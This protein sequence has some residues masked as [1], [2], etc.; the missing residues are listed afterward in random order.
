MTQEQLGKAKSIQAEI[1]GQKNDLKRIHDF[2][3]RIPEICSF[4]LQINNGR[5]IDTI[6]LPR[7]NEITALLTAMRSR[8]ENRIYELEKEFAEI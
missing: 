7:E 2:E 8:A 3:T 5:S 1:E 6:I 4:G